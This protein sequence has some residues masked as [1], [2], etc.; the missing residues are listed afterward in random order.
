M[1]CEI[2]SFSANDKYNMSLFFINF[3]ISLI[4]IIAA[5]IFANAVYNYYVY[6][7]TYIYNNIRLICH[8]SRINEKKLIL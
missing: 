5:L 1:P 8:A 3:Y 6:N 7:N 4:I 2:A